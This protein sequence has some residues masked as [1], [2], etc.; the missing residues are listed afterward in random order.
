M[1]IMTVGVDLAKNVFAVHGIDEA[2][3]VELVRPAVPREKLRELIASLPPCVISMKG[4]TCRI[5]PIGERTVCSVLVRRD[6]GSPESVTSGRDQ[7]E[8]KM[9][10]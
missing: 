10:A 2:G 5:R 4:S 7:Q 1:S 9:G 8:K 3:C 6:A